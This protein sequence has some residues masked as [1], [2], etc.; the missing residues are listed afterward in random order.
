MPHGNCFK[1]LKEQRLKSPWRIAELSNPSSSPFSYSTFPP[2]S[3]SDDALA[4]KS[5]YSERWFRFL[6]AECRIL[7]LQRHRPQT[8]KE[9][10]QE[11]KRQR[12][13]T[14]AGLQ[15]I[16]PSCIAQPRPLHPPFEE[17]L[18][19]RQ[20]FSHI[21][22]F[23]FQLT[24]LESPRLTRH[25]FVVFRSRFTPMIATTPMN[26][27][28]PTNTKSPWVLHSSQ[29]WKLQKETHVFGRFLSWTPKKWSNPI[30]DD[31]YEH[32]TPKHT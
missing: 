17:I 20:T 31:L 7:P 27:A 21:P 3:I 6:F 15:M 26:P 8:V 16:F 9:R 30:H 4:I 10:T 11:R 24:S 5:P 25:H 12:E 1:S 13:T 23:H 14:W 22:W 19:V 32:L 28:R 2:F 29:A 18:Y